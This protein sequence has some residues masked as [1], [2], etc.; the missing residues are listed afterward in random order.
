MPK[1]SWNDV[2]VADSEMTEVVEG[3]HYSPP[4]S[5]NWRGSWTIMP[6]L[7]CPATR[8]RHPCG[9][10]QGVTYLSITRCRDRKLGL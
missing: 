6:G 10:L 3:N 9:M 4:D 2:V 7:K 5:V 8:Y 1:A